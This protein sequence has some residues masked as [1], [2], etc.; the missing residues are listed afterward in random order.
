MRRSHLSVCPHTW[1]S[2]LL[3]WLRVNLILVPC[4]VTSPHHVSCASVGF[5]ISVWLPQTLLCS[6]IEQSI[7]WEADSHSAS[8]EILR[9]LRNL[10]V[11]YHVHGSPPLVP[12]LIHMYPV[13]IFPPY[14]PQLILIL[15]SIYAYVFRMVSFHQDFRPT[16]MHLFLPYVLRVSP[17]SSSLTWSS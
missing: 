2:K 5:F 16:C 13:D 7:C 9:L 3:H 12:I 11:H 4:G 15:S 8:R 1:C 14:F 6:T 10:K 17:I